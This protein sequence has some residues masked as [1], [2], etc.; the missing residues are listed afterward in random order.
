MPATQSR[1]ADRYRVQRMLGRGGQSRVFLA[2]DERNDGAPVV[3]KSMISRADSEKGRHEE[4]ELFLQEGR[5][6]GAVTHPCL[7]RL[8]DSFSDD[9]G[10]YVV[11]EYVGQVNL[12]G[13]LEDR[14]GRLTLHEVAWLGHQMLDLLSCLHNSRPCVVL[15]DIKPSNITCVVDEDG[16]I[17]RDRPIWFI[18]LTI[19][20]HYVPNR[21]DGVKMGSPGYAPP[22][23]YRGRSQPRSDLYA[24]AVTMFEAL[25]GHDP[26]Q[27]PFRM[28]PLETLRADV[29]SA[30]SAFFERAMALEPS[31]RFQSAREMRVALTCLMAEE[32]CAVTLDRPKRSARRGGRVLSAGQVAI[33]IVLASLIALGL[34][35]AIGS[36]FGR[37]GGRPSRSAALEDFGAPNVHLIDTSAHRMSTS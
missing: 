26:V 35:I 22:E 31:A 24:L 15:R 20:L 2:L 9:K 32:Q 4:L 16:L 3:L 21:D 13:V 19:A 5:I 18:D 8:V 6:L 25:T 7:P 17:C 23:Q 14:G 28:P 10:H 12:E 29:P 11:E 36:M 37:H 30:W 33:V 27:T 1:I 34:L